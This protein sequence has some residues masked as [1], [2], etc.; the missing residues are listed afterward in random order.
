MHFKYQTK[1]TSENGKMFDWLKNIVQYYAN[2]RCDLETLLAKPCVVVYFGDCTEFLAKFQQGLKA[3]KVVRQ[4]DELLNHI[5]KQEMKEHKSDKTLVIADNAQEIALYKRLKKVM[6]RRSVLQT[7]VLLN[8]DA[9]PSLIA[10]FDFVFLSLL[11]VSQG[12][13][14]TA[15]KLVKMGSSNNLVDGCPWLLTKSK[16]QFYFML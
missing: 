8:G 16:K 11:G 9:F 6:L 3:N 5:V 7:W 1:K 4:D 10:D 13:R 12:Q 14:E 2:E 15:A